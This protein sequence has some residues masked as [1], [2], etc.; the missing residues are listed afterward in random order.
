MEN[1]QKLS[2]S[3][4]QIPSSSVFL[5]S[6]SSVLPRETSPGHPQAAD[7]DF[8]GHGFCNA[9]TEWQ[10]H[11]APTLLAVGITK[12]LTFLNRCFTNVSLL[13]HLQAWILLFLLLFCLSFCGM[14]T[15]V[16]LYWDFFYVPYINSTVGINYLY[17]F[18]KKIYLSLIILF[19]LIIY[20]RIEH[21]DVFVSFL[22]NQNRMHYFK[23]LWNI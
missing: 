2:F 12:F 20:I 16:F 8:L 19:S 15:D 3:Y 11:R 17:V 4:H 1:W 14:H 13:M 21:L 6:L 18:Y 5:I 9:G 7:Q 23:Y 10:E 22:L